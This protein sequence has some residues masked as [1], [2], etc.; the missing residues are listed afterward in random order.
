VKRKGTEDQEIEDT[1]RSEAACN[2]SL[3]CNVFYSAVYKTK[4]FRCLQK[5]YR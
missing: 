1:Y 5:V 4:W 2:N 3:R